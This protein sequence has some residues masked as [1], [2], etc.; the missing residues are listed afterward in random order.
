MTCHFNPAERLESQ[1]R[2]LTRLQ[3]GRDLAKRLRE[4]IR[5]S[6]GDG[7]PG[8][9]RAA[10]TCGVSTRT[11]QRQLKS[12]GISYTQLVDQARLDLALELLLQLGRTRL[13][14]LFRLDAK[15]GF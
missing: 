11:L 12:Q 1:T 14:F 13:R 8:V 9:A 6:L 2:P 4:M 15:L 7:V 5:S 10:A 3:G